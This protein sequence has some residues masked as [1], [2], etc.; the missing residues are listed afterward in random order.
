MAEWFPRLDDAIGAGQDVVDETG[1][2]L[3]GAALTPFQFFGDAAGEVGSGAGEAAGGLFGGA[4][5]GLGNWIF[6]L[7]ALAIIAWAVVQVV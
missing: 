1:D 7:A 4:F 5:S 6:Q 3:Y 2:A